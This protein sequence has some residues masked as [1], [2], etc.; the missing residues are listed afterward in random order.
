MIWPRSIRDWA[1]T[2]FIAPSVMLYRFPVVSRSTRPEMFRKLLSMSA[3]HWLQRLRPPL[4]VMICRPIWAKI[5]CQF[6]LP[7]RRIESEY[8][9]R[10]GAIADGDAPADR[11]CS[12]RAA[13]IVPAHSH[14]REERQFVF[15]WRQS[16]DY[17]SSL[18]VRRRA[19][20]ARIKGR[21][22]FI[23]RRRSDWI[24]HDTK[25]PAFGR[26]AAGDLNMAAN[27]SVCVGNDDA[28]AGDLFAAPDLK[29]ASD[30]G[31]ASLDAFD[32][33]RF[34]LIA[35]EMEP[36]HSGRR[37]GQTKAAVA[38]DLRVEV[39]EN[40]AVRPAVW[41]DVYADLHLLQFRFNR[42]I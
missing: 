41:V 34:G 30:L 15:S 18:P 35:A 13:P 39:A 14:H 29:G 12:R 6:A 22:R 20:T 5:R 37:S 3:I 27:R 26:L 1:S 7:A 9:S 33:K 4:P 36:H 40:P 38:A 16:L 10:L 11:A 28:N 23:F 32:R 21:L 2:A 25:F 42:R 8:N 24:G 31:A 17:E 19:N